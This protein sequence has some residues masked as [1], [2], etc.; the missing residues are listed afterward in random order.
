LSAITATD[1]NG[2]GVTVNVLVPGRVA[3]TPAK[4]PSR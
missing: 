1:L 4:W 2:T 3:N